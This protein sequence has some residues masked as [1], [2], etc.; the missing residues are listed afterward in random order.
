MLGLLDDPTA[1]MLRQEAD[2]FLMPNLSLPD[3]AEGFGIAPIECMCVGLPVVAFAVDAL[4]E[5]LQGGAFLIPEGDYAAF[6]EAIHR[7]L[8]MDSCEEP[9]LR[10]RIQHRMQ[11][12][13]NWTRTKNAY[14]RL[15]DA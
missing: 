6:A 11:N 13:Y 12:A 4:S 8:D 14:L 9:A 10:T 7:C 1:A 15:F 5:S 3:D 2:L